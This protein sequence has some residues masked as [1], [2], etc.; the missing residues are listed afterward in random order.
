MDH[1]LIAALSK[2]GFGQNFICWINILLKASSDRERHERED[3]EIGVLRGVG[4]VRCGG[5]VGVL[6]LLPKCQGHVAFYHKINT[7]FLKYKNKKKIV[8]RISH[9]LIWTFSVPLYNNL[10][11]VKNKL[12]YKASKHKLIQLRSNISKPASQIIGKDPKDVHWKIAT[13]EWKSR[14]IH[15]CD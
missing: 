7:I 14:P 10:L 5:V 2:F 8:R 13:G 3:D 15:C 11:L 12:F 1:T 6:V 9:L 4:E